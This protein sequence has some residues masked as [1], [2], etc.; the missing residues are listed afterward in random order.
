MCPK[1]VILDEPTAELF[2]APRHPYT[3]AL[4]AAAPHLDGRV[5]GPSLPGDPPSL[6]DIPGGC[7]FHPRCDA[8]QSSCVAREPATESSGPAHSVACHR[9]RDLAAPQA[10]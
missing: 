5:S 1:V 10:V 9:W 8:A 3:R 7:R 4:L 2:A 6:R